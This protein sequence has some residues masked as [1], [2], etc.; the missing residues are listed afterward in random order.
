MQNREA[1][2]E[3]DPSPLRGLC[4]SLQALFP[5]HPARRLLYKA[6]DP[7]TGKKSTVT[8]HRGARQ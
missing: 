2:W 5:G 7:E 4:E 6:K 8:V 3:A 1:K